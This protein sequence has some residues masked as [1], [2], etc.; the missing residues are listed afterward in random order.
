MQEN[1]SV[2]LGGLLLVIFLI[3]GILRGATDHPGRMMH[4]AHL[5]IIIAWVTYVAGVV[6][7]V[8]AEN[9][10]LNLLV[11]LAI[12]AF[13]TGFGWMIA[14]SV[15]GDAKKEQDSAARNGWP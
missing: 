14:A 13:A 3:A 2:L 11:G 8:A 4:T 1:E 10:S 5:L 15:R 9:T 12:Y 7:S 6:G